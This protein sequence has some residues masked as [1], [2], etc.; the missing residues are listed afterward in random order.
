VIGCRDD[1]MVYLMHQGIEAGLA[2]K[3][4]EKVRKGQGVSE[5]DQEIM[6]NQNIPG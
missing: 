1:I 2:F 6:R 3:I 5:E 4:M